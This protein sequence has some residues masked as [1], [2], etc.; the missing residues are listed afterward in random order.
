MERLAQ[1]FSIVFLALYTYMTLPVYSS[2]YIW[3]LLSLLLF[4]I[5]WAFKPHHAVLAAIGMVLGYSGYQFYN[6]YISNRSAD[7]GWNTL[8]WLLS[9]PYAALMGGIGKSVQA[10]SGEGRE[11]SLF[12]SLRSEAAEDMKEESR[13]D[14]Q[15]G[16]LDGIAFIYKLEEEVILSLR[17]KR[18][19]ALLIAA[20]DRFGEYKSLF[21]AEQSQWL[22]H[23]V[24][25][26]IDRQHQEGKI[27]HKGHLGE[28]VFALI[29]PVSSGEL[30]TGIELQ[31][32]LNE[33]FTELILQRPRREAQTK[34]R[35]AYGSALCPADGIEARALMDK[36]QS[37]IEGNVN[38][39]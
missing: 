17:E 25:E 33:F 39:S 36:A 18:E 26:W 34:I 7:L 9:F 16:F 14:E 29:L 28:G 38:P 30:D 15:L 13:I 21:G 22:L 37:E 8:I 20:I 19:F 4:V 10:V 35:M 31:A 27:Q 23:Q 12:Q 2:N 1:G 6:L 11:T 5:G 24:A 32:Q 3:F